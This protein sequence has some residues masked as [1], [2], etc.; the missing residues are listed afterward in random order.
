MQARDDHITQTNIDP[1][2]C[3]E[4]GAAERIGNTFRLKWW[5]YPP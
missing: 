2:Y 4:V 5:G 3:S 1:A